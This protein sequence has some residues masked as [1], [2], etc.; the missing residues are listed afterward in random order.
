MKAIK[1]ELV[2]EDNNEGEYFITQILPKLKEEHKMKQ[3]HYHKI[4]YFER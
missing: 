3:V 4:E 2:L 1:V